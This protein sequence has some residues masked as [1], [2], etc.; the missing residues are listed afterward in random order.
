MMAAKYSRQIQLAVSPNQIMTDIATSLDLLRWKW[1]QPS[2]LIFK[3]SIKTSW[4][5]WGEHL[6]IDISQSGWMFVESECAFPLQLVDWGKN[7]K[8]V[9]SFVRHL[10]NTTGLPLR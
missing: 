3:A 2:P 7:K 4:A 9:N 10:S 8:N 5:S 6:L 1:W